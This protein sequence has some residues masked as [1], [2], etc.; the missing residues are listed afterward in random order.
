MRYSE[1]LQLPEILILYS[2]YE[3]PEYILHLETDR[4]S[5]GSGKPYPIMS[6]L[7]W[8]RPFPPIEIGLWEIHY[9]AL[10][11]HGSEGNIADQ[12]VLQRV[13]RQGKAKQTFHI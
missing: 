3:P 1:F 2:Q 10:Q 13:W 11:R 12:H 7:L 4:L 8:D 6:G 5:V 9:L